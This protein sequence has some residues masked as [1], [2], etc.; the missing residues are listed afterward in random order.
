[1]NY[2]GYLNKNNITC[3]RLCKLNY[4]DKHSIYENI[5]D[6]SDMI[7][8]SICACGLRFPPTGFSYCDECRTEKALKNK[9]YYDS[10]PKCNFTNCT[11]ALK[12]KTKYCGNHKKYETYEI[13]ELP[14]LMEC[15]KCGVVI[16]KNLNRKVC[17]KCKEY[18]TIYN[19][20]RQTSIKCMAMTQMNKPCPF[21][22]TKNNYCNKHQ[23]LNVKT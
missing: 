21:A 10:L 2:C 20:K 12:K 3:D 6:P 4:C 11:N 16:N 17:D 23:L 22:V 14:N 1:M 18:I 13:D 9:L 7:K 15:S 5:I 8:Y 19:G